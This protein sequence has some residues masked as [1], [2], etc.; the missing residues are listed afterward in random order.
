MELVTI[1]QRRG[2]RLPGG[3]PKQFVLDVDV[4][5]ATI[6]VG[7]E[8]R[9]DRAELHADRV[10]WSHEPVPTV[11]LNRTF[12]MKWDVIRCCSAGEQRIV[13]PHRVKPWCWTTRQTV[14]CSLA[15][16]FARAR[17]GHSSTGST[18]VFI[19]PLHCR[20]V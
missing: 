6:V 10:M 7:D 8:A 1:G 16:S 17:P 9:L 5:T 13:A 4:A 12:W 2:L 3:A 19:R 15:A 11:Q 18:T 20:Q 14:R